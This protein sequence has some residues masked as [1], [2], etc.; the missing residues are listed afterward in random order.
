MRFDITTKKGGSI[1]I[2]IRTR[3]EVR[4]F[5]YRLFDQQR[6]YITLLCEQIQVLQQ[7]KNILQQTLDEKKETIRLK[8]RELRFMEVMFDH[9]SDTIEEHTIKSRFEQEKK[10]LEELADKFDRRFSHSIMSAAMF[11]VLFFSTSPA[12]ALCSA[13]GCLVSIGY[14]IYCNRSMQWNNREVQK[15]EEKYK[16]D[17]PE[18]RW[19]PS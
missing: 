17:Y 8:D 1:P 4:D 15:I 14:G 18:I 9:W 16:E 13:A 6:Q 5:Q 19:W 3:D 12:I 11:A 2:E 10:P 7:S